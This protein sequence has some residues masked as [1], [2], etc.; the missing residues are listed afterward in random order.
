M[1]SAQFQLRMDICEILKQKYLG[2]KPLIFPVSTLQ[3]AKFTGPINSGQVIANN[4]NATLNSVLCQ[5]INNVDTMFILP[6]VKG[7]DHT[8]IKNPNII[9]FQLHAGEYGTYPTQPFDTFENTNI[10][11]T[12]LI[13]FVNKV[14]KISY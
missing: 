14:L 7:T 1:V 10:G 6:Y 11:G 2:G 9:D 8:I 4:G 12:K 5:A 13:R 3:I